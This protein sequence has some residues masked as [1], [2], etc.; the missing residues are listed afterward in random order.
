MVFVVL[1]GPL[2]Y[3]QVG[4]FATS[5]L[6]AIGPARA[7][8]ETVVYAFKGGSDGA[9]PA[10]GLINVSGTLYGTTFSG[11]AD[12]GYGGTVFSVTPAGAEAVVYAF[13]GANDAARPDAGLINVRGTLYGTT[14]DGGPN[15]NGAVFKVTRA[16]AET[17]VYPFKGGTDGSLPFAKLIN[18]GGTL[19]GTTDRG[20]AYGLG[21][22]F[23]VKK[24]GAETVV[25]SFGGADHDGANPYAGVINVGST[26]YGTTS[27]GGSGNCASGC[28]TVFSVTPAGAER[29]VYSF[30]GGTDGAIPYAGLLNVGGTLYGTTFEGGYTNCGQGCG[31]VFGVTP[32]GAETVVYAFKGGSDGALPYAAGL[33]AVHSTLYGT[34]SQGGTGPCTHSVAGCGTVFSVTPAGAE[35][36]LYSFGVK[37]DDGY[38]PLAGLIK[39]GRKL[40]GTTESGGAGGCGTVFAVTP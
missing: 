14:Q 32:A 10:A 38:T 1:A 5:I 15:N 3:F 9:T 31:T 8:S 26:L 12:G 4:C 29:V 25:Y 2:K 18:V 6:A 23:S 11:G 39:V 30:K 28:G 7:A 37:A 21:T 36:V 17:V 27:E 22:V 24:A 16:G 13:N 34:T 20:G 33:I 35:S 40:Y 19:Y